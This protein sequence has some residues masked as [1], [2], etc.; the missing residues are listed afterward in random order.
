MA[1]IEEDAI[2]DDSETSQSETAGKRKRLFHKEL[3]CMM[4]GFGDE[5]VPFTESVDLLEDLVVEYITEMTLKAMEVG[6]KGKVHVEDIVFLIRKDPKKY[7]RVKDLLTM[8]EEL[9]KARKAFDAESYGE[10]V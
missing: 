7:A 9:K 4:Y 5:Q 8:N 1:D 3:R 10:M 2:E 6:K